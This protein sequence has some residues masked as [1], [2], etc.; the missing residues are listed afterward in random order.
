MIGF[1]QTMITEGPFV[2]SDT[3]ERHIKYAK[4][5]RQDYPAGNIIV[6]L[7]VPPS[8]SSQ[9][10]IIGEGLTVIP[11]PSRRSTFMLRA[12][13]TLRQLLRRQS[14]D[15]VT[16]Q[17]PFD[18][19]LIGVWLKRKFG[20]G[21]NVQMRSSFL[22][23]PRWINEKPLVYRLFNVMGKWV[24]EQA[25]TLRVVS[26]GE[27]QRLE[28]RFD[29]LKGKIVSLHPLVNTQT[30]DQLVTDEEAHQVEEIF[31]MKG[32]VGSPFLLFVGRL[33]EQK[34]LVTLIKA[35]SLVTKEMPQTV[36]VIAGNGPQ[37]DKLHSVAQRLGIKNRIIWL[38]NLSLNSLRAW[39]SAAC[40][41]ILPSYHEGFGK[42]VVESYLLGTPVV[43]A[44]FVSA[45]ELIRDGETGFIAPDFSD[46]QWF[47]DRSL[48]LLRNSRRAA[49]MGRDGKRHLQNYLL[50][51]RQYLE[52]LIEIWRATA[53]TSHRDSREGMN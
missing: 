35:F 46:Y 33:V 49:E 12:V 37:R 17:T 10:T 14:F 2:P 7:K 13:I 1:D 38:G 51:E 47:A 23:V 53:A 52:T 40:A 16:T 48:E 3:R 34:N 24:A 28:K 5:L 19:G 44:P 15:V 39:Y 43:A 50:P 30:F 42:V 22:D 20:I 36:L 41:T 29:Q 21:L 8:W 32:W 4:A 18:D 45:Q 25:D 6:I 11:V 26:D 9:Q 27:K 31:S